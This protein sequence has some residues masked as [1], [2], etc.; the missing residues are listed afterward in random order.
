M[1]DIALILKRRMG[2]AA[3]RVPTRQLPNW[4]LRIAAWWDPAVEQI[5]PELGKIKNATN[6]KARRVLGW[7]PRSNEDAIVA[8]AESLL[9]LGL[10]KH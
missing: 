3:A 8:T 7:Q 4:L 2:A 6:A 10:V 9:R 1:R 5:V